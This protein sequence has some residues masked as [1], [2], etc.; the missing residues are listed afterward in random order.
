MRTFYSLYSGLLLFMMFLGSSSYGQ[1]QFDV[2]FNFTSFDCTTLEAFVDVEVKA[3]DGNAGFLLSDQNYRFGFQRSIVDPISPAIFGGPPANDPDDRTVG[4]DTK[5]LLFYAS[6]DFSQIAFYEQDLTGSLDTLVS[7]NISRTGN[8]GLPVTSAQWETVTRMRLDLKTANSCLELKWNTDD[9][10]DFPPT[11]ITELPPGS[12]VPVDVQP[13]NFLN[14]SQCFDQLCNPLSVDLLSF[15]GQDIGC[16][17]KL[18]WETLS[19]VNNDYFIIEKSQDGEN[20]NEIGR[21]QGFGLSSSPTEYDFE[22]RSAK[23]INYY[24]LSQVDYDGSI[25]TFETIIVETNCFNELENN[26]IA[27]VFPNPVENGVINLKIKA[28]NADDQVMIRISDALGKQ[29]KETPTFLQEGENLIQTELKNMTSGVYTIQL[30]GT[31]WFSSPQ[32]FMYIN[33]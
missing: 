17:V 18:N 22:D 14:F 25:E 13:G 32:K 11:T 16:A 5:F 9:P 4:I 31:N 15:E 24:R 28:V 7:L 33:K 20:F 29:I 10:I 27:A 12:T 2:R 1:G 3:T 21:V 30:V 6:P 8:S 19:E 26:S 23:A